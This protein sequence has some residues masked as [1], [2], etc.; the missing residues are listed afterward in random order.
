MKQQ[1]SSRAWTRGPASAPGRTPE[2]EPRID[3]LTGQA[4]GSES[5]ACDYRLE[6]D[7]FGVA[8]TIGELGEGLTVEEIWCVAEV[9]SS[10]ELIGE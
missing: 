3:D 7:L 10:A 1:C 6:A 2:R 4:V 8:N 5:A 9:S